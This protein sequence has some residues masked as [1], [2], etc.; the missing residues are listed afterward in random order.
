MPL[1]W[2]ALVWGSAGGLC[3]KPCVLDRHCARELQPQPSVFL[4]L[5]DMVSRSPQANL[6]LVVIPLLQLPEC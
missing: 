4:L 5:R 6:Q 3:V 2:L 1:L